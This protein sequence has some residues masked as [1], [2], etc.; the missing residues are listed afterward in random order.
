M[1]IFV[2]L[3]YFVLGAVV[4]E[5]SVLLWQQPSYNVYFLYIKLL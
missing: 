4:Y 2:A 3:F 5:D 1:Y